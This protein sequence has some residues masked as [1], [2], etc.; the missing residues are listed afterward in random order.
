[1]TSY[2]NSLLSLYRLG[3]EEEGQMEMNMEE[4]RNE[5]EGAGDSEEGEETGDKINE[6]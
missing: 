2:T 4:Y 6:D 5:G 1:M 3:K